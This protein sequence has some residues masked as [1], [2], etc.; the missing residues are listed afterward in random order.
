MTAPT[1][2]AA[3]PA[4][5]TGV[6]PPLVTPLTDEQEIDTASLSRLI[7]HQLSAGVRGIFVLGTS[8]ECTALTDEQRRI[9]L[10]VTVTDVAGQVPVLA[11]VID[12]S[13]ARSGAHLAAARRAGVDA[14]VATA[15]FYAATHPAEMERH[16]R[17]LSELA[18]GLPL[19][20]Y[21]IP[22]RVNGT[23]LPSDLLV[24]LGSEGVLAGVKDSGG[25]DGN[26]RRTILARADAELTDFPVLTGSEVTVDSALAFG[27]DGVVPGL[28]NVDPAGY[29]R[30][31][32][33]AKHGRWEAARNEQERLF[34]LFDII[35][36]PDASRMGA[37]SSALGAF[38]MAL[39]LLGVIDCP[40]TAFPG[41]PLDDRE[42]KG[43]GELLTEAG[44]R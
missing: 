29:V 7:D 19:Y 16:F 27:A 44:L 20:A 32:N 26:L 40:A 17:R 35:K 37:S 39:H 43:I 25:R 22:S 38:K 42:K 41:I 1:E 11:G 5:L 14:L 30:L 10:S 8:G 18:E 34:R 9:V 31:V 24:R 15:P 36:V 12:A 21:N 13:T 28:G 33:H 2:P 23:E 3:P 4:R 6:I